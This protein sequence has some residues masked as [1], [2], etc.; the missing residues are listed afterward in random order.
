MSLTVTRKRLSPTPNYVVL[1]P[2]GAELAEKMSEMNI[3]IDEIAQRS[4]L[5]VETIHCLLNVEITMT[6]EIAEHLEQATLIPVDY[7]MRCEE[8]YRKNLR[9]VENHPNYPVVK[10]TAGDNNICLKS[11]E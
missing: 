2:P 3:D 11:S 6:L 1:L 4:G 7:W 8:N 10:I 5:S 9:F